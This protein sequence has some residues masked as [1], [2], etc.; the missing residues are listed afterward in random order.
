MRH[1]R[2]PIKAYGQA[3]I[4]RASGKKTSVSFA[5]LDATHLDAMVDIENQ[6][7]PGLNLRHFR[8]HKELIQA[9]QSDGPSAFRA[10]FPQT[11]PGTGQIVR[12]HVMADVRLHQGRAPTIIITEPA[13]IVGSQ[14]QQ[15]RQHNLTLEDLRKSSVPLSHVAILETQAQKTKDDCVMYSLNYA[16][17]A[18]KNANQFDDIHQGLQRGALPTEDESRTK[19]TLG[20]LE[21]NSPY[22]LMNGD[23]HAA[24]GADF[25][26]VDFYK[27]GASLTQARELMK[28]PD[29][30]MAG[31]VNSENHR[32]A[33]NLI[34][35]NQAFRMTRSVLLDDGTPSSTQFS[36]SID[37]FRLQE[38]KRVLAAAQR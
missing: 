25:L 38:I 24:F 18:Y 30:R 31:R 12:H 32:E 5:E 27:H 7:N 29:G 26:P 36:A 23:T 37:G 16:I 35:R 1:A 6:R 10:I 3:A 4:D 14:F 19:T 9:L 17:K 8:D 33:E 28:R 11:S 22:P 34:Q 13:V 21:Q 15:L 2:G 20:A